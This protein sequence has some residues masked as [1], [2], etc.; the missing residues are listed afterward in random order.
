MVCCVTLSMTT[1]NYNNYIGTESTE[2][3]SSTVEYVEKV[4]NSAEPLS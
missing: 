3:K 2:G 1:K 4:H